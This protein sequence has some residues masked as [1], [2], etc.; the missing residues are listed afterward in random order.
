MKHNTIVILALIVAT[1]LSGAMA[2]VVVQERKTKKVTRVKRPEFTQRDWDGIYFENL[3]EEG[4]VGE[5]PG[6]I[7]PGNAPS[8]TADVDVVN[9]GNSGGS[10]AWSKYISGETIENEVKSLQA[11]LI[12]D[13]TSPVKFKSE[14]KKSHQSFSMLSMLFGVIRE[15]DSD[16]RWK[17]YAGVAQAS[18]ERAAANARV[19]TSQAYESCKRRRGDLEELVRGGNFPSS[20][21]APETLDWSSVVLHSPLMFRLQTSDALLKQMTANKGDF[22]KS[23]DKVYHESE[24]VAAMAQTLIRENMYN[25]DD[26]GY[27]E[28]AKAMSSA[29]SKVTHACKNQDYE[30]ASAAVN[31]ISQ[32][33]DNCHDDWK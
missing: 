14:Y 9:N 7:A 27:R 8:I 10:V 1:S 23:I 30:A 6:K 11:T 17:K 25:A 24:L 18:F 3:F 20:D 16:V 29:A 28:Y 12:K 15:Y 33:C 4:L 22:T 21:P 26:D 2:A 32:S 31:L 5:R 19:G 13:I